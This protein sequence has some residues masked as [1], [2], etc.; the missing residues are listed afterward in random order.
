[1]SNRELI[2]FENK[3]IRLYDIGSVKFGYC[4]DGCSAETLSEYFNLE[5]KELKQV[6]SDTIFNQKNI[7]KGS[8]GDGIIITEKG[9]G[10]I[11]RTADC[12]PLF[13]FSQMGDIAGIIHAGWRGFH[14][15]IEKKLIER[16]KSM[17]IDI[18]N[19][20]FIAGP[21]I[22]GKCYEVG[23]ELYE[24]F[25]NN[26]NRDEFFQKKE[27][28]YYLDIF[29]GLKLSLISE[30]IPETNISSMNICTFCNPQNLP[31][32]RKNKTNERI[33]NFIFLK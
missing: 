5:F 12:V 24:N 20:K 2:E 30:G 33:Y 11:I 10:A 27:G 9:E 23:M 14:K 19:I 16:L 21:H 18:K 3:N 6:H 13:F 25:S 26:K 22:E 29:K 4:R 15:G 8:E 1:M 28:K 31:S 32:Y 17:N 7:V